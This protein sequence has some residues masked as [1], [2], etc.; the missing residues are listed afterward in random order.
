[1]LLYKVFKIKD[2]VML[3]ILVLVR[4]K[5]YM[6]SLKITKPGSIALFIKCPRWLSN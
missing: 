1:M 4:S 6:L 2:A 3:T 5:V